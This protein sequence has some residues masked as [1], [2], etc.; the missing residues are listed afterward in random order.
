MNSDFLLWSIFSSEPFNVNLL[1]SV[2]LSISNE[3][4]IKLTEIWFSPYMSSKLSIKAGMSH[5][6]LDSRCFVLSSIGPFVVSIT[7]HKKKNH[8]TDALMEANA[9]EAKAIQTLVDSLGTLLLQN[10]SI[11]VIVLLIVLFRMMHCFKESYR[12]WICF[13]LLNTMLTRASMNFKA[14][15]CFTESF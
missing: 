1:K 15:A 5:T 11:N 6:C 14:E 13:I 12:T 9:H 4:V 8:R 10:N 7:N 2:L 3:N